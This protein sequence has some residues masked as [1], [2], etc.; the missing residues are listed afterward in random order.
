MKDLP[1]LV[2]KFGFILRIMG[3]HKGLGDQVWLVFSKDCFC[4]RLDWKET[5]LNKGYSCQKS[6]VEEKY[7]VVGITRNERPWK[8]L[9]GW[10]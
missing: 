4:W 7:W 5:S 2:T 10:V 9:E 8:E 6:V 3:S 1:G